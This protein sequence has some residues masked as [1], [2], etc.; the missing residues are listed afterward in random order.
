MCRHVFQQII[1]NSTQEIFC[2]ILFKLKDIGLILKDIDISFWDCYVDR[3][4]KKAASAHILN[5]KV[6]IINSRM[7][8]ISYSVVFLNVI[9]LI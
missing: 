4:K 9:T 7:R 8:C 3:N 2:V 5:F 1:Q 6:E